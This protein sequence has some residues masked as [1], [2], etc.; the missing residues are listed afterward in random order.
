MSEFKVAGTY[1]CTTEHYK[2]FIVTQYNIEYCICSL[3]DIMQL[4]KNSKI[5]PNQRNHNPK[6]KLNSDILIIIIIIIIIG[7]LLSYSHLN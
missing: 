3:G 7:G 1:I 5:K 6:K 4:T 2:I